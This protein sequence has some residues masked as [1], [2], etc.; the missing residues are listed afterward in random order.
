[1]RDEGAVVGR[2]KEAASALRTLAEDLKSEGRQ[3]TDTM[4]HMVSLFS[5]THNLGIPENKRY[6]N[7]DAKSAK[8][9]DV[10]FRIQGML[11]SALRCQYIAPA[12]GRDS[13]QDAKQDTVEAH[14]NALYPWLFRK[15]GVRWDYQGRFWQLLTGMSYLQQSYEPYYWDKTSVRRKPNEPDGAYNERVDGYLGFMGPP[16][17]V[18]SIDPRIIWPIATPRG[19]IGYVKSYRVKRY[20]FD[21]AMRRRGKLVQ[22][23]DDG[24]VDGVTDLGKT[25]GMEYPEQA[26]IQGPNT[27]EYWEYIDDQYCYY[28]VE[29]RVI[30]SYHHK[31]GIKIFPA[32]A[33]QT[34][35]PEPHLRSVGVLWPVRNEIPQ[36]DF[37]RTLWAQKAYLDVFP[38]LFAILGERD[39]PLSDES[40]N[41]VAWDI[42]PGTVKQIRGQLVNAMKDAMS[43]VDFR[44]MVEMV[45]GDI[46]LATISGLARGVAGAQQPGYS[47]NQLSQSMRTQWKPIIESAELQLSGMYEHYLWM[48]KHIIKRKVSIFSMLTEQETG[49]LRGDYMDLNPDDVEDYAMVVANLEPELPID[50]QGTMLTWGKMFDEGKATWEEFTREGLGKTNPIARRRQVMQDQFDKAAQ[51]DIIK[52][53]IS[54]GRIR[55]GS[56]VLHAQGLDKLN[57]PFS[58]DLQ[59]LKAGRSTQQMQP[60]GGA[61]VVAPPGAAPVTAP[62]EGPASV[63]PTAGQTGPGIAPTAGANPNNP[64]PGARMG[65]AIG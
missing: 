60:P 11:T 39:N 20:E 61:Q 62:P 33:L 6:V 29:D 21:E 47:I 55:L 23:R 40:G 7:F 17:F 8:P 32:Y 41:P 36:Y 44:A 50:K 48:V 31:G 14:L 15:Y 38:Q 25:P 35:L 22:Y 53:A 58:M 51:P 45:A 63:S 19:N 57:V 24:G 1:M 16:V 10:I 42:E 65:G 28:V 30:D 18:E 59:A 3:R 26:N 12:G 4:D 5:G 64:T 13:V 34:G 54:L 9:S 2:V 52:D 27:V 37:L 43:G 46:D 49:R 56:E